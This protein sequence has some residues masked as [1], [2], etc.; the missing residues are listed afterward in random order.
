MN[1]KAF[2]AEAG[3]SYKVLE[4]LQHIV[5]RNVKCKQSYFNV[6]YSSLKNDDGIYNTK[7]YK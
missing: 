1:R 6:S 2:T 7:Y 3:S 5:Q 4:E